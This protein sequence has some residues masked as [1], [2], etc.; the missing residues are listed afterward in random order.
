MKV[1]GLIASKLRYKGKLA[2]AATAISFFVII[3]AVA[4]SSGFSSE[5]RK[6]VSAYSG[7][8]IVSNVYD[9]LVAENNP[10]ENTDSLIS[11]ISE[12]KGVRNI[13]AAIYRAGIVVN[14]EEMDGVIFKGS[15]ADTNSMN[16]RI[17]HDIAMKLSL[18]EGDEMLSYFV[19]D[20]IKIRKFKIG[21]IYRNSL[22]LSEAAVVYVP[23]NDMRR[24]NLWEEGEA[25]V[26]ELGIDH[27]I[28]KNPGALRELCAH[29]AYSSGLAVISATEKY[30]ELFDW[31]ELIEYNVWAII[32]L[33]ITVAGFNMISCL[34]IMLF[35]NISTIGTLKSLG[36]RDSSIAK[37]FLRVSARIAGTGMI[38]GNLLAMVFCLIQDS[39]HLIR[40]N[41]ENYFVSFVPVN[42]DLPL[43]LL[44]E[45]GAFVA[46]MLLLML[47]SLFISKIDP[48][49]TVKSE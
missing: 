43:L 46:I 33:M 35:R 40:L 9:D 42:L 13:S 34:L 44:V 49:L 28:N 48:S 1:E 10:L 3:L 17:P 38:I 19:S 16:V 7:D 29:I 15:P 47:P 41:P 37:V 26:L 6:S 39:T 12:I 32:A 25:S 4:I 27:K 24:L 31:L 11:R 18:K 8:I 36:M 2:V 30:S 21:E 20:K 22:G 45:A 14:G 23:I 5:I